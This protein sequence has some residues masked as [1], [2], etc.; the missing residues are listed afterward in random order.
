[1]TRCAKMTLTSGSYFITLCVMIDSGSKTREPIQL[2]ALQTRRCLLEAAEHEF[3][4]RG[5][6]ATTAKTIAERANSATGSF[7]QYFT[8]KDQ[9]LREIAAGRYAE[10]VTRVLASLADTPDPGG[11]TARVLREI[12]SVMWRVVDVTLAWH[13][14]HRGLQKVIN[15]RRSVDPALDAMIK[16][17]ELQM[18]AR[19][20]ALLRTWGQ[21]GD[22][23]AI[24]YVLFNAVRGAV[25]AHVI[26]GAVVD[27][28][29]FATA[30]VD[31][32]IRIALPASFIISV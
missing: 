21:R 24:A 27:D 28:K 26:G 18:I 17:G 25:Q 23:E 14:A 13:V 22:V 15:E 32:M 12:R 10:I 20:A 8:S 29:R 5:Y 19:V 2:R 16:E 1:M 4:H 3:G 31:A 6:D 30:A 11:E 9:A 7:Y